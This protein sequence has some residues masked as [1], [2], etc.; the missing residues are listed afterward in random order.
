MNDR[1][2]PPEG[3]ESV[4]WNPFSRHCAS[5]GLLDAIGDKWSILI[6]VTLADGELRYGQIEKAVDGISQKMLSQR[7]HSLVDDGLV[8][9]TAHQEI[10]PKVVYGLTDLGQSAVPVLRGLVDWTVEHM[11]RVQDHR[12][13][14]GV[15]D[16]GETTVG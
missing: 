16:L 12:E 14:S 3:V 13:G 10:P 11:S 8:T 7:L 2:V 4:P 1:R 5:R 6:V 9:R 15:V